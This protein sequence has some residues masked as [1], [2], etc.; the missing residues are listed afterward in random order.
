MKK[1]FMAAAI[2][3]LALFTSCENQLVDHTGDLS[4]N[5]NAVWQLGAKTEIVATSDGKQTTNEA[6]YTSVHFYLALGEFPF[7]HAIA[8]KGSFTALDLNDVDVDA[9]R[10][11]YNADK[12]QISFNKLLWLTEG[13]SYSMSITGTYDVLELTEQTFVIQQKV[14]V[15][16]TTTTTIYAFK[17]NK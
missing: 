11:T 14:T 9:C 17:K 3:C 4:G 5:L 1:L 13:L 10:Y 15:L 2:A 8:K 12:A 6:D 16:N 7:P